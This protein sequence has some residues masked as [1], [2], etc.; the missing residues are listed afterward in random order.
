MNFGVDRP[1]VKL[2]SLGSQVHAELFCRKL[3]E[4]S[5]LHRRENFIRMDVQRF[6]LGGRSEGQLGW[7]AFVLLLENLRVLR[8]ANW[9]CTVCGL[10][11][12]V[13]CDVKSRD[14]VSEEL[15]SPIVGRGKFFKIYVP[16]NVTWSHVTTFRRNLL[17]PSLGQ[18]NFLKFMFRKMWREVTWRRFG[19]TFF[20]H[21]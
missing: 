20:P 1:A 18:I 10:N 6:W 3:L 12:T 17:P 16:K 8:P 11:T 19:G 4:V 5:I 7:R 21:R 13:F 2:G 15:S 9:L 14:D